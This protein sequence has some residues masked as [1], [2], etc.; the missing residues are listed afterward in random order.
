MCSLP[1]TMKP[2]T[3]L[4][5]VISLLALAASA[6]TN[7]VS[8]GRV[9]PV[10][11]HECLET[12]I[13]HNLD[14]QIARLTPEAARYQLKASYGTQYD[15]VLS[16]G[17][18]KDYLGMPPIQDAK[19]SGIDNPYQ[20]DTVT[21]DAGLLGRA[22]PGL[23]YN[24]GGFSSDF[25]GTTELLSR[26]AYPYAPP[27]Y[28]VGGVWYGLESIRPDFY[29]QSM[30]GIQLKQSLLKNFWIDAG[31]MQIDVNKKNLKITE[32]G[33][34][35]QLMN[36]VLSVE[37]A[38]YDLIYALENVK[39]MKKA[40][41][42]AQE[43][44]AG[45][46]Q[47]VTAGTLQPLGQA[48]SESK[49]EAAK[50]NLVAAQELLDL[51]RNALR[52]LLTDSFAAVP[53]E[54]LEPTDTLAAVWVSPDR[55]TC[56]QKALQARP[57]LIQAR[58][59][60]EKQGIVVRYAR[61]QT[62]PTVDVVG[63]YGAMGVNDTSRSATFDDIWSS[64]YPAW[65]VGVKF[66][67][68]LS[69]TEARNKYKASQQFQKQALLNL[70]KVEQDV[71]VQLDNSIKT[72]QNIYQRI[73][74]TRQARV[75]AETALQA[76]VQK[77]QGGTSTSFFVSDYERNLVTARTAEI[78]AVVDFNKALAQL[79]FNEGSILEKNQVKVDF[80]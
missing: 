44:L 35:L 18:R 45:D 68:P 21:Y 39:V 7:A 79:A 62:Y 2:T 57:D 30:I 13:Q 6:Q 31:R 70:R 56:L 9:R 64:S 75:Y 69:N 80:K 15:P 34:L 58:L 14:V 63:S 27:F 60:L 47:R 1:D 38:Y 73:G 36:T 59:E 49:V 53:D 41:D 33:L 16:L 50:A 42:L 78:L 76:E 37:S 22:T 25:S 4:C 17:V 72:L 66:A 12:A 20:L 54:V 5:L 24:L 10:T 77:Y 11:L 23:S 67:M 26:A 32:Q 28:R 71:F 52:N 40:L 48:L 74:S 43:L 51:N 8:P 65:S 55:A 46:R 29:Y 3:S 61:N 19:K